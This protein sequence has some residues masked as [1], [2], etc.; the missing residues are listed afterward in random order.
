MEYLTFVIF[1]HTEACKTGLIASF[2]VLCP[3]SYFRP[4]QTLTHMAHV[5]PTW[6]M[7]IPHGACLSHMASCVGTVCNLIVSLHNNATILRQ[8]FRLIQGCSK[9]K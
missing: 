2:A 7:L 6:R 8:P 1:S 5:Y 9:C 3:L 4:W